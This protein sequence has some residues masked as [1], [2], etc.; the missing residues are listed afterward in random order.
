MVEI[1]LSPSPESMVGLLAGLAVVLPQTHWLPLLGVGVG[2]CQGK[3]CLCPLN[4][5]EGEDL[6]SPCLPGNFRWPELIYVINRWCDPGRFTSSHETQVKNRGITLDLLTSLDCWGI[7][8][9]Q[10]MDGRCFV[11]FRD[12]GVG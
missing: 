9:N 12:T 7:R 4:S 10:I 11:N 3:T 1:H 6:W 2:L 5:E 8:A